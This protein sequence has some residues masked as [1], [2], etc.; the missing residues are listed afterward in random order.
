M[1]HDS[2]HSNVHKPYMTMAKIQ[3][4]QL[5]TVKYYIEKKVQKQLKLEKKAGEISA[6]EM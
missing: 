5:K 4:R 2:C 1:V 3:D 6:S